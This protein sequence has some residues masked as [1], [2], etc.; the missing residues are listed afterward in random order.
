MAPSGFVADGTDCDDTNASVHAGVSE[1]ADADGDGFGDPATESAACTLD[2]G[3]VAN[4]DDCD[5]ARGDVNPD[6]AEICTDEVDNDCANGIDDGCPEWKAAAV[7]CGCASGDGY[8][9]ASALLVAGL[10]LTLRRNHKERK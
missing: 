1:Y 5:D 3:M 9:G 10:A 4:S 6:A 2:V 8:G 7:Y